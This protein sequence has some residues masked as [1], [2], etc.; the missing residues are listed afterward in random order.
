VILILDE[1]TSSQDSKSNQKIIDNLLNDKDLTIIFISHDNSNPS[2]FNKIYEI[3]NQNV[4][5]KTKDK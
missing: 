5:L 1:P 3:K 2:L 4:N